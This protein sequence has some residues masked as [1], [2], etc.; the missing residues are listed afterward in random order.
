MDATGSRQA[1]ILLPAFSPRRTGDLGIGDT[2]ALREWIDW[3][4]E[5]KVSFL[6]LLPINEQG[7]EESPYCAISST[8]L[9]PIYL[10]LDPEET[11][12]LT[13]FHI[14]R[15]RQRAAHAL[16]AAAVDY[17]LVRKTKRELLELAWSNFSNNDL[18]HA[19]EFAAF[20][21]TEKSWLD[22]YCLF[23]FLM[24][25][26]GE[27]LSWDKW[28]AHCQTPEGARA[29]IAKQR[30]LDAESI[31]YTLGFFAFVQWLCFRQWRAVREHADKM[32]VKLM[33]D[34]PIGVNWHSSDVFFNRADF[35]LDW[36]GGT[37]PEGSGDSHPFLHQW[38]QNWGIPLYQWD[39]MRESGF[40]WWRQRVARITEIFRMFRI[41]HIL[42]FYRIYA[43]PWQQARNHEFI[44]LSH[45]Q[46]AE[47]TGGRLP[48]WFYRPDDTAENKAENR[49]DGDV[50]L[51]GVLAGSGDAEIIAE[52]LGWVPEYVRPHLADLGIASYRIPHWD[53]TEH[54]HPVPGNVFPENT[55]ACYSTHDH[56]PICAIWRNCLRAIEQRESHDAH[57]ALRV[58]AEFAGIPV[59]GEW[60]PFTEGIRLRLVKALFA[61]NSRYA[62]LMVT[63]LF[64]LDN[65]INEPG[66]SADN[67]TFRLPWTVEQIRTDG[68]LKEISRL[69]ANLIQITRRAP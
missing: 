53:C 62:C 50:R 45:D 19:E 24:V 30:N 18:G 3:A 61:A 10:T 23:R 36:C 65:R 56:D 22:D 4:A 31:D 60:P 14:A 15:A 57:N 11:P 12:W 5:H 67:W 49:D 34:I 28:P 52:D 17:P 35:E 59:T 38:G 9:D 46:A 68:R 20:R 1:G 43:F 41:D 2:K 21:E 27:S 44:G 6:Q 64:G 48:R 7:V 8:A 66:T 37:P 16:Q 55:F 58:I 47:R 51:R 26:H 39:R 33:G 54:G 42:G 32:G 69:F 40:A 29:L 63:E 25:L 13:E